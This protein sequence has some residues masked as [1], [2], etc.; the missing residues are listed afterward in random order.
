M[1]GPS[2]IHNRYITEDLPY[3]L[4]QRSQLGLLVGIPTPIID[5][6]IHLGSGICEIDFWKGRTL[7]DLGLAGMTKEEIMRYLQDGI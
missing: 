7:Q 2:K 3:G 5:S 4:V 1:R 6:I